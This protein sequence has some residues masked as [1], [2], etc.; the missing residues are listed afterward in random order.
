MESKYNVTNIS[1]NSFSDVLRETNTF[2]GGGLGYGLVFVVW[3][4]SFTFFAEY[5]NIDALK[6]SS[7]TAW[8]ISILLSVFSVVPA[9]FP[10]ALFLGVAALTAYQEVNGR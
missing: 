6:A 7:F 2:M 10:M 4:I 5:P 3:I 1:A 9:S 8:L